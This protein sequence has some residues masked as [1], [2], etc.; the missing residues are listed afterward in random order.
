[1]PVPYLLLPWLWHICYCRTCTKPVT[2]VP[3][4]YLLLPYLYRTCYCRACTV[5]VT[6]VAVA[7][8]LLPY[9]YHTCYCR[10]STI[11]VIAVQVPNLL[12]PYLYQIYY[13]RTCTKPV[14]AVPVPNLL[15]PYLYQTY[16]CSACTKPFTAVPVPHQFC[17]YIIRSI[18]K[19]SHQPVLLLFLSSLVYSRLLV[20][21]QVTA[22]R[23]SR[24]QQ[25]IKAFTPTLYVWPVPPPTSCDTLCII[26]CSICSDQHRPEYGVSYSVMVIADSLYVSGG[27]SKTQLRNKNDKSSCFRPFCTGSASDTSVVIGR[28]VQ[29]VSYKHSSVSPTS[30]VDAACQTQLQGSF[31]DRFQELPCTTGNNECSVRL[32]IRLVHVSIS[33]YVLKSLRLLEGVLLDFFVFNSADWTGE[34]PPIFCF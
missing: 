12:L 31:W 8:L 16:Y 33:V 30:S 4:P 15:L 32:F 19:V 25:G 26:W 7:H 11:P 6:A 29:R 10:T 21:C 22:C 24:P 1:V 17:P 13:C 18:L 9:L 23:S 20:V 2:A 28:T 34:C 14:T 5:P 3:V 27:L